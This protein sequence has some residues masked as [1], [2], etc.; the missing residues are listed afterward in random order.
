MQMPS[1]EEFVEMT[2]GR[3]GHYINGHS[4][5]PGTCSLEVFFVYLL[6]GILIFLLTRDIKRPKSVTHLFL[7]TCESLAIMYY[8][9]RSLSKQRKSL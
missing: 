3:N 8:F 1:Q 7:F 6:N 5:V 9:I 2:S 4:S